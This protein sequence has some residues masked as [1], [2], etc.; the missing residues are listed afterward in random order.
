MNALKKMGV[1]IQEYDGAIHCKTDGLKGARICLP[2]PSVGATENLMMAGAMAEGITWIHN[3]AREPEVI[4]LAGFLEAMGVT[5]YGAG[6]DRIGI[7]GK[8]P[9]RDAR[10]RVMPDRI[11]AGTYLL[12]AAGAGGEIE[13]CYKAAQ[14][15]HCL[16]HVCVK[17][18][19]VR[20]V[21][22]NRAF[23]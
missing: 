6:T 16:L 4:D 9:L 23:I 7:L 19:A 13:L 11:V 2:Y 20:S 14:D 8:M 17:L 1:H 21:K 18:W 12:A 3:A 15:I 5:V 10:Y 22:R